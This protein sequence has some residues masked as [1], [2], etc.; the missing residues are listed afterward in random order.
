MKAVLCYLGR[1]WK[2][3]E[4]LK[5]IKSLFLSLNYFWWKILW[6]ISVN[7]K[8]CFTQTSWFQHYFRC[9]SWINYWCIH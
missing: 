9:Y 6:Q 8:N 3:H 7:K 4:S 2:K 5:K 1:L